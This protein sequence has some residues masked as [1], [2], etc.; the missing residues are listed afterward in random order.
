ME[1]VDLILYILKCLIVIFERLFRSSFVV[2]TIVVLVVVSI[3]IRVIGS[4][5][6]F[7]REVLIA[8]TK[9]DDVELASVWQTLNE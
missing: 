1:C 6:S 7:L 8:G 3:S 4:L 9:A 2:V 5:L